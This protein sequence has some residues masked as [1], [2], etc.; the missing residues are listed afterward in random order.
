MAKLILFLCIALFLPW[1]YSAHAQGA[2]IVGNTTPQ[3]IKSEHRVFE[4]YV[5]RYQPDSTAIQ[6][7]A[8]F[9]DSVKIKVLFGT[10]CHDSK[11]QIPAFMKVMETVSNP[12]FEIE[13]V[14]ISRSKKE[15]REIISGLDLQYTPTFIIYSEQ[16]E[17]GRIVEE[18]TLS[19]EE[20]LVKIF[21]SGSF[22]D[23]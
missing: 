6:Y 9:S 11:K 20:D 8:A 17:I 23:E 4:I 13:Y 2:D 12:Y 15:P 3:Q 1:S 14:G 5:K 19:M 16:K 18:P 7:L 22:K 21:E 10:W